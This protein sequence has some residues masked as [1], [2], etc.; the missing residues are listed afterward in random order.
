MGIPFISVVV[1]VLNGQATIKDC[2]KSLLSQS[3]PSARYEIII[4]D[5]GSTDRTIRILNSCQN[6][7]RLLRETKKG[8][9][10]ARNTGISCAAGSII[11]F[12]DSDCI[13]DKDWLIHI[14]K[15]FQIHKSVFDIIIKK[16]I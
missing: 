11:A 7:L 8:S 4:V 10:A 14:S 16:Q 3:Y 9:Y 6:S 2:V 1:P 12:T 13:A 5:N 15:P